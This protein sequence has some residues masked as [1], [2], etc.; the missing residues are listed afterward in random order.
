M[1]VLSV[2]SRKRVKRKTKSQLER[3]GGGERSFDFKATQQQLALTWENSY[4]VLI[5]VE[6]LI[7]FKRFPMISFPL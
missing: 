2:S 5:S 4:F 1:D 7:E 3:A 6:P